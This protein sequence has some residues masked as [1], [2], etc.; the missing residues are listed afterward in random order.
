MMPKKRTSMTKMREIIRLH[1]LKDLSIRQISKLTNVSRPVVSQTISEITVKELNYRQISE[2]SDSNLKEI[3]ST[4]KTV[5]SKASDLKERFS[6]YA[7]ELKKTGVTLQVLWEEYIRENPAGLKY[8]QFC[9]HF[10]KWKQDERISMHIDHKAGDQIMVDYTGK[11]ME[12]VS[13]ETG[14]IKKVE[15]FV[16]IL[17]ASQLTYVEASFSQNQESFLRSTERAIRYCGGVPS[18]IVPDNLKSGV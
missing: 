12:L 15:I 4:K 8:S 3:L 17:P 9:H 6:E 10:Q 14:E 11:K 18:A 13:R 7:I 1:E 2:L 5:I 16:A